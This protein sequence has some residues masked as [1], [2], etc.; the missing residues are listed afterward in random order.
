MGSFEARLKKKL[1]KKA[2]AVLPDSAVMRI[3]RH[4]L[5]K[6]GITP[7]KPG[8]YTPE[9]SY[10]VVSAI[11]N[12]APYLNDFFNSLMSQTINPTALR[13]IAVDD[14][15]TDSSPD[16]VRSWQEKHPGRIE[17]VR[18]ENGGQASAR[19]L[20]MSMTND[21]E[22]VTFI[23]P[24]DFVSHDYF[25]QVDKATRTH[26]NLKMISCKLVFYQEK[27]QR[28][29]DSHPLD[30]RFGKEARF[31]N[32]QDDNHPMQLSMSTAFFKTNEIRKTGIR[33][34]EI[35]RPSF[36]D[37]HFVNRYLLS[38]DCGT[39]AF[40]PEPKYYYRKRSVG[41]STLDGSWSTSDKLL[42]ETKY[43][44]LDLLK[45]AQD[46]KKYVP[47]YIQDTVLYHLTWYFKW[48]V[49]H[50]ERS[51]HFI[52]NGS[53]REFHLLLKQ[54]FSYI[55]EDS[56]DR[57]QGSLLRFEWKKAILEKYKSVPSSHHTAYVELVRPS[58]K[59]ILV[60][61]S[62]PKIE[63]FAGGER[64]SP[65]ETKRCNV[66]F[67]GET[68][69]Q[70]FH[71]WYRYDDTTRDSRLSYHAAAHKPMKLTVRAK[72]YP[73]SVEISTL[74]NT[75]TANWSHYPQDGSWII[76]DRDTQA[77]DNAEH[78]YRYMMRKHP[79]QKCYFTLRKTSTDWS[80][81]E[82]EGFLLLDFG[83]KDHENALKRCSKIVSSHADGFVHSYFK[84]NFHQSKDF[85]FLQHG[86]TKDDI[87]PWINGKPISIFCTA[88][89]QER[90]SI[91]GDG[92]PYSLAPRQTVLT[93]FP[94]HDELLK[95][96]YTRQDT[97]LIMPTWR[98]S[99][100][101]D[102]NGKGNIREIHSEFANSEYKTVW[103]SFLNSEKLKAISDETST[104]IVFYPHANF[105]PYLENGFFTLPSY[106]EIA[107]NTAGD[108]IQDLF[109][110]AKVAITDYS[111]IAFDVAY[112]K[113][114]CLYYQ[115]DKE[116][117][118]SGMQA[119]AKGY[120]DYERDGFGP[121][122]YTEA[123]LLSELEALASCDFQPQEP[124]KSR[125][126]NTFPFRDGRCCE[127]VYEA[128]KKLDDIPN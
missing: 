21:F 112:L 29:Q 114:T 68:L 22:W 31:Y 98:R 106:V 122:A 126:E 55:A 2:K 33:V 108:S 12:V 66:D 118:F 32:V 123:D 80:R 41:T 70:T 26:E 99:L 128:I 100:A 19:N 120:F 47:R 35:I 89:R 20:G 34:S 43:G 15:S 72:Q 17:Y 87:S 104:R 58:C 69:L 4:R 61:T 46:T 30:Y 14:G 74:V 16:V 8:S 13:I 92:S 91:C 50:K 49:G 81:L 96:A 73:D 82:K 45:Y 77:D 83:S 53:A 51:E 103:E 9:S 71:S 28:L 84:D 38:L 102:T 88:T 11:Y 86:I 124:Y 57:I 25:E 6:T 18:K 7:L 65:I 5:E 76:M 90:L 1:F 117:F 59:T 24:D 85:I 60:R 79:E 52:N 111:S 97:I 115:F 37:A 64:L 36:E 119:Y 23:D 63:L 40:C 56:V 78:F 125:I 75:F 127:R 94:R 39:L 105:A 95:Q 67:L 48:F 101:G 3:Q 44:V 54:I 110:R 93:G 121:V 10:A 109:G 42:I 62:D 113:K 27:T 107:S 116:D